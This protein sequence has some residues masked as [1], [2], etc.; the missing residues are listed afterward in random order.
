MVGRG[1]VMSLKTSN[2]MMTRA[3][4]Q[5]GFPIRKYK[6]VPK[7]PKHLYKTLSE[8]REEIR[9]NE[10]D[11]TKI[12]T[13]KIHITDKAE[14]LQLF[15]LYKTMSF[16]EESIALKKKIG[17]KLKDA[18][19]KHQKYLEY[20]KKEHENFKNEIKELEEYNE[21][22]EMK[23]S[24]F[25]LNTSKKNKQVIY[26]NYKRLQSLSED[27]EEYY[28]LKNWL[29]WA[30]SLPH[31]ILHNLSPSIKGINFFYPESF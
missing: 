12:L 5:N 1:N 9:K 17:T 30:T 3:M 21:G 23:Y 10:P 19:E 8:V 28:K 24:I 31:D 22:K 25:S 18:E 14:L 29:K 16:S 27:S 20:T 11:I 4:S 2:L 6:V 26:N 15:E 7:W 13:A